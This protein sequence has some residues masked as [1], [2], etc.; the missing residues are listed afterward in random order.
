MK[1]MQERRFSRPPCQNTHWI[2]ACPPQQL[3]I[4]KI[5]PINTCTPKQLAKQLQT[6]SAPKKTTKQQQASIPPG[7]SALYL[8]AGPLLETGTRLPHRTPRGSSCSFFTTSHDIATLGQRILRR[9]Y[10]RSSRIRGSCAGGLSSFSRARRPPRGVSVGLRD[11]LK[12]KIIRDYF[13]TPNFTELHQERFAA[14]GFC[15]FG[16]RRSSAGI[17]DCTDRNHF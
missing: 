13:R 3:T 5:P 4:P 14:T 17:A 12:S 11:I 7:P 6:Q 15:G 8:I 1:T 16:K 9:D 10:R 2:L